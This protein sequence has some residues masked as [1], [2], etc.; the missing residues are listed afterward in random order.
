M[1]EIRFV[2]TGESRGYPFLV[3]K[4]EFSSTAKTRASIPQVKK[5]VL[6]LDNPQH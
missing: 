3:C 1:G 6:H 5:K 2:G 4:K